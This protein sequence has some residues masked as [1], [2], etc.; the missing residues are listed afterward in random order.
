MVLPNMPKKIRAKLYPRMLKHWPEACVGCGAIIERNL[1]DPKLKHKM[2]PKNL[3]ELL[4][5]IDIDPFDPKTGTGGFQLHHIRYDVRL[6]DIEFIRFMCQGCNHK[7]ELRRSEIEK[8]HNELSASM[9]S[10]IDKHAIFLDW[11]SDV[12]PENHYC[13]PLDEIVDS[14]AYVSG[15]NV[16]TVQGWLRPLTSTEGPFSKPTAIDGVLCIFVKGMNLERF[17]SR[18]EII[19]EFNKKAEN[20][21]K[22]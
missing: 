3:G 6:D 20:L 18:P 12:M 1:K 17:S 16:K 21:K 10:N 5:V 8:Y 14:G 13:M 11:L 19:D 2:L 15:A 22:D 7:K 9:R 4:K